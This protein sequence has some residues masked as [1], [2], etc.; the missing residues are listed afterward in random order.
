[1]KIVQKNSCTP[2]WLS[3]D[4]NTWLASNALPNWDV[5]EF[6]SGFSTIWYATQCNSVISIEHNADWLGLVH[7][8]GLSNATVILQHLPYFETAIP[9]VEH[10]C[11]D[12]L[13]IDGRNRVKCFLSSYH[14]VKPGGYC[15]FDDAQR[16]YYSPA[17]DILEDTEE[18]EEVQ[19]LGPG[20]RDDAGRLTRI[21]KLKI[22]V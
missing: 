9:L 22:E 16:D 15:I 13:V 19:D 18:W 10:K 5:L 2:P 14:L 4:A 3:Y 7:K 11:Y 21:F 6:G 12:L 8:A 20:G 1:M 17:I